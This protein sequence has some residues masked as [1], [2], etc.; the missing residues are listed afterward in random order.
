M[1]FDTTTS[2]TGKHNGNCLLKKV[3]KRK[4]LKLSCCHHICEV[5]FTHVWRSLD[6]KISNAPNINIIKSLLDKWSEINDVEMSSLF[7]QVYDAPKELIIFY[8]I[9]LNTYFVREDYCELNEL[10]LFLP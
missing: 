7:Q 9:N 1:V 2:N 3:L 10:C 8:K 6:I 5:V 4:V